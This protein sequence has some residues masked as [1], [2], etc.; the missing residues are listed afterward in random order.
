MF[1]GWFLPISTTN[2]FVFWAFSCPD[3]TFWYPYW[4]V[5][6]EMRKIH[7]P[8]SA[9]LSPAFAQD[10]VAPLTADSLP[11][12][13][14]LSRSS[15]WRPKE[16][17]ANKK[18]PEGLLPAYGRAEV[19]KEGGD[20]RCSRAGGLRAKRGSPWDDASPIAAW[21]WK[22]RGFHCTVGWAFAYQRETLQDFSINDLMYPELLRQQTS[23][24]HLFEMPSAC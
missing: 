6:G 19:Q 20:L 24:W 9:F 23:S 10:S 12:S 3:I 22:R 14:L 4:I 2:E 21:L 7:W 11:K 8:F 5:K 1:D 13:G 18:G 16:E 17:S 15:C